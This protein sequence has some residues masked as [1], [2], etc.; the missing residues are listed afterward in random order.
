MNSP[1]LEFQYVTV[2]LGSGLYVTAGQ[3]CY[4]AEILHKGAPFACG[5]ITDI[6]AQIDCCRKRVLKLTGVRQMVYNDFLQEKDDGKQSDG[7][8]LHQ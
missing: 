2:E 3:K 1:D 7:T 8:E 4:A 6:I 5:Y